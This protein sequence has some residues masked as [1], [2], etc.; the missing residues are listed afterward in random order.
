MNIVRRF[1]LGFMLLASA[2]NTTILFTADRYLSPIAGA[3][4]MSSLLVALAKAEDS[5][6]GPDWLSSESWWLR[7][8]RF[9]EQILLWLPISHT[10][11]NV[12]HEFFGH[13]FVSRQFGFEGEM[14]FLNPPFPF[15]AG[16]AYTT[17]PKEPQKF[18]PNQDMLFTITGMTANDIATYRQQLQWMRHQKIDGRLTAWY[19]LNAMISPGYNWFFGDMP[20][21]DVKHYRTL[22]TKLYNTNQEVITGKTMSL[23]SLVNLLDP[24]FYFSWYGFAKY[25][26]SGEEVQMPATPL[27]GHVKYL[28]SPRVTWSPF[29]AE[30]VLSNYLSIFDYSSRIYFSFGR[31]MDMTNIGFGVESDVFRWRDLTLGAQ[32]DVF[33]QPFL[34]VHSDSSGLKAN[35]WGGLGYLDAKYAFLEHYIVSAG[36]GYKSYGYIPGQMMDAG[37]IWRAALGLNI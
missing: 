27:G 11:M 23:L 4:N 21:S 13:L 15:G 28:P 3:A 22:L 12:Q 25:V 8:G 32:A 19:T 10:L 9:A 33:H 34:D 35:I 7:G 24:F 37:L 1:L 20:I 6:K 18:S 26:W 17:H 36:I 2:A 30:F 31:T 14:G 5:I 29:G 16:V